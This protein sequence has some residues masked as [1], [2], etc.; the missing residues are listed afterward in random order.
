MLVLSRKVNQEMWIGDDVRVT[1]NAINGNRVV[2]GVEAPTHVRI[3]RGE[4]LVAP[5]VVPEQPG[6]VL[7]ATA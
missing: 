7:D 1:V 2:L 3:L 5:V 4:L 6:S